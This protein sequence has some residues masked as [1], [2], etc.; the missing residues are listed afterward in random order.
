MAKF[1]SPHGIVMNKGGYK[2]FYLDDILNSR[3]KMPAP[4]QYL[5]VK[6]KE[7]HKHGSMKKDG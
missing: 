6:K 2:R 7:K 3:S 1:K 5:T 4:G